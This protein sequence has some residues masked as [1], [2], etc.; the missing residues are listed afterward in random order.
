MRRIKATW[1]WSTAVVAGT[2]AL[3][4]GAFGAIALGFARAVVVPPRKKENDIR[5][6]ASDLLAETVTLSVTADSVLPGQYT[7]VSGKGGV[8]ISRVG[9]VLHTDGHT[10]TRH[11]LTVDRGSPRPGTHA[12]ISGWYYLTP[13]ELGYEV[14][15]VQINTEVGDAPAWWVPHAK[16]RGRWAIHVHGRGVQRGETI[17]GVPPFYESGY[18]NL[19]ISYRNDGEAPPSGDGHSS[20]GQTEWRDVESAIDFAV[21]NGAKGIVLFGWSMGGAVVLQTLLRAKNRH[22]IRGVVLD[23]PVVDWSETL[24]SLGRELHLPRPIQNWVLGLLR[25]GWYR[26]KHRAPIDLDSLNLVRRADLLTVPILL[27]HSDDDGY[28]VSGP[29]RQLAEARPDLVTFVPFVVARH[30]KLWN[31]DRALWTQ[32][33]REWLTALK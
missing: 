1:I 20:L 3:V 16:D 18:S 7:L 5:I 9:K 6:V 21:K 8:D 28:V 15:E 13:A 26:L 17:R 27:L 23:S 14:R 12:R 25:T 30:A 11:L 24:R 32:T 2:V 10:V 4:G 31:Y 22:L 29:S 33:I 19:L